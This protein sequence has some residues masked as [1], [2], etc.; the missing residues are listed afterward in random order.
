MPFRNFRFQWWLSPGVVE[1]AT[2]D[3]DGCFVSGDRLIL[4]AGDP[5]RQFCFDCPGEPNEVLRSGEGELRPPGVGEVRV[6]MIASPINPSDMMFVRGIYSIKPQ[7]PQSPGFEGV[8][9]VEASGGGLRG[10]L[11]KGKR[12]VVMNS[13][14][15]NWAES[16][17]VPATQVIPIS[18]GLSEDQAATF[19]V[20]PATAWIMTQEVLKVPKGGWLLQTAAGS[21]L[22]HMI[23][24]LGRHCGYKT[25]SVIRRGVHED[26]LRQAGSDAVV[27]FDPATDPLEKLREQV[28]AITGA[29]TVCHALDPV[30]GMTASAV[31]NC[32]GPARQN[33]VVWFIER[34][35][36]R[37]W[38]AS[39]HGC[40][41]VDCRLPAGRFYDAAG[42]AVQVEARAPD[43][44]TDTVRS[45][46]NRNCCPF[47]PGSDQRSRACRRGPGHHRKGRVEMFR[48]VTAEP[49]DRGSLVSHC[50]LLA[51]TCLCA[52]ATGDDTK[53][54]L[55][56]E[57]S[58]LVEMHK[59]KQGT[60]DQ[61]LA[62][63]TDHYFTSNSSTI[64]KYD[65][66][67]ILQTSKQI[68][69]DGVNHVGAIGLPR[70]LSLGR[71]AAWTREWRIR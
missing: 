45:P 34:P 16:A 50:V 52:V 64:C 25:L 39:V 62:L 2:A 48:N 36:C 63:T 41:C 67:W 56:V 10:I 35:E 22:G 7:C 65:T 27:V 42:T 59:L 60:A 15:G 57:Q 37:V 20:N 38:S 6:R 54:A 69:I 12:V 14:G 24:R 5:C 18:G 4:D 23:A 58:Q 53:P 29:I 11:F 47:F 1:F 21:A 71:S 30:G 44:R 28:Q 13:A 32:L 3:S 68:Q 26:S 40:E 33:A 8:G 70:R 49:I 55:S 43:Y 51:V 9:V 46:R 19:F 31:V 17:V 66:A 61:G